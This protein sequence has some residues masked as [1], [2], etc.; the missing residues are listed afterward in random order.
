[1]D[2]TTILLFFI[3]TWGLGFTLHSLLKVKE[4]EELWEKQIMRIG[5]GL[6]VF[7]VLAVL[8]NLLHLPLTWWLF[9]ILSLAYPIFFTLK[10]RKI[11]SSFFLRF[12]PKV[13]WTQGLLLAVFIFTLFMHVQGSFAYEYLEDDDPWTHA[14][15][16]KYVSIEKTLNV[17]YFRPINYLDPYPPA[18]AAL[19]GVL[20]QTSPE[21]QWTIK[22]FNSLLIALSIL[23]FF[24]MVKVLTNNQRLALAA[25]FVLA[26]LPSYLSH[27]IWSHTLIPL[28]F[29]VLIYSYIRIQESKYWWIVTSIIT[30][31]IFLTHTRQVLKLMIMAGIFF[32][33]VWV[34]EKKFPARIALATGVGMTISLMWWAFKW[35]SLL[36]MLTHGTVG[37]G[38]TVAATGSLLSR[39]ISRL[40]SMF[41]P[42]GG[43]GHRAYS[44]TD[45]FIAQDTNM[46]NSPIG[47]GIV[48][49]LLIIVGI[50]IILLQHRK[51]K[52]KQNMWIV[53]VL[54]WFLF[55]FLNVNA[56]T[57][58][59]PLGI[60]PFRSW[61]QLALP[62]AIIAGYA[63][64]LLSDSFTK[65]KKIVLVVLVVLIFLTSGIH[66]YKH[67]TNPNWP[68]GGKWTSME[69]LQGYLWMK[70]NIPVNSNVFTYSSQNKV[71]FG[72][73]MNSCVW[74][75]DYRNFHPTVLEKDAATVSNWLTAHDY[76]Y[77][78]FGGMEVK[79]LANDYGQ[80]VAATK[81]NAI[82]Q[83]MG[84]S[85]RFRIIYQNQGFILF[86]VI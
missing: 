8:L 68:P 78:A 59:L 46:I 13:S 63:L 28:L 76:H 24:Y 19:M 75:D 61:M 17:P 86:E 57:F 66:N 1:M 27:F 6:C 53:I 83:E 2:L 30:A 32:G 12:S 36:Q 38:E 74:C 52:E 33:V 64:I 67:N 21:A 29:M 45:F 51:L 82:I 34:Y 77:V 80:D 48:V 84:Q 37:S 43:T 41:S 11:F 44:F 31:A 69:E 79:Y 15:E 10:N 65:T 58:H 85:Q 55:T 4:A 73:N 60:E 71:V 40:P 72:F 20:H 56:E 35:K 5:V 54:G 50:G 7:I 9:L 3:Y 49:S 22:F 26:M 62:A 39:I 16:M 23:F 25:T 81:V 18:Y 14:R 47:W 70:D 42:T